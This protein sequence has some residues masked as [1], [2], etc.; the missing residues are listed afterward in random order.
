MSG[1]GWEGSDASKDVTLGTPKATEFGITTV[2]ITVKNSSSKRSDYF[3]TV[4]A[5]SAD[6]AT[7][8]DTS[9]GNAMGVEPGQTANADATFTKD[10]PSGYKVVVKEVQRTAST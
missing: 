7:Q 2:P 8:Y 5:E 1:R 6:G 4:A 9:I 3:V 10:L